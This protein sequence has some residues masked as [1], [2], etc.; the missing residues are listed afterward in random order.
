ML[1][2][3]NPQALMLVAVFLERR[4]DLD[5]TDACKA[6]IWKKAS[7]T[8]LIRSSSEV[9]HATFGPMATVH[10]LVRKS[11]G[12]PRTHKIMIAYLYHDGACVDVTLTK[13]NYQPQDDALFDAVLESVRFAE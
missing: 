5:S 12:G 8:S 13:I 6:E 3:Q 1:Y 11:R 10:A 2:A 7:E 9:R 4:P